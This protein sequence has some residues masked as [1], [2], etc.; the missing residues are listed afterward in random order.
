MGLNSVLVGA[1]SC[2]RSASRPLSLE[3][4]VGLVLAVVL[5]R[6]VVVSWGQVLG[7]FLYLMI[8]GDL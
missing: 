6:H 3:V 8:A 1:R 4:V 5:R 2:P 7:C